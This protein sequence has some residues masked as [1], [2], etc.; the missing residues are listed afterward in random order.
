[1]VK[2]LLKHWPHDRQFREVD[3]PAGKVTPDY[4]LA[5][6]GI[7]TWYRL[8]KYSEDEKG[9]P[10]LSPIE[11]FAKPLFEVKEGEKFWAERPIGAGG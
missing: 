9:T 6:A 1:M 3:L 10:V 5:V 2:I 11:N 8:F 7:E 4:V